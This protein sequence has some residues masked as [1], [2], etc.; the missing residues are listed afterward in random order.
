MNFNFQKFSKLFADYQMPFVRSKDTIGIDIGNYS[1]KVVLM[2][3]VGNKW[4]LQKYASEPIYQIQEGNTAPSPA[5]KKQVTVAAIKKLL[6]ENKITIRYAATSVSGNSV[7]V[8][9]VKFP[10]LTYQQLAK[11]IHIEAESY[12]PFAVQDVNIGFQILEDVMEDGAQKMDTLLVATKK[13]VI[14]NKVDILAEA[15]L[16]PVVIDVD[17][18][19]VENALSINIPEEDVKKPFM[20]VNCGMLTTN[21]SI[22]ENGKSRVVRDIFIAGDTFTK[23][24]QRSMQTNW[25]QAEEYKIKYGIGDITASQPSDI[26]EKVGSEQTKSQVTSSLVFAL[27]ELILEIQRSIDYYQTQGQGPV[28][29]RIEKIYLSGGGMLLKNVSAHLQSELHLP[30][31]VFNPFRKISNEAAML[32]DQD[33]TFSQYAVAV[34]LATRYKKDTE[35]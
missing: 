9:Y 28:E 7:I 19:A 26:A 30:V 22:I 5:E 24:I 34:G 13:E 3:R 1:V 8:R 16:L 4:Q 14:Q 15:G 18:L 33:L 31:E 17:S 6:L 21:I 12:I 32:A 23:A 27:K 10:K 29:N 25:K 11:T 20:V 2:K 35:I